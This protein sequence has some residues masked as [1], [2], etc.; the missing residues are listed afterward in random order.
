LVDA[1]AY[2]DAEI[3]GHVTALSEAEIDAAIAAA[4]NA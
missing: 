4:K 1:K 2:T 3:A